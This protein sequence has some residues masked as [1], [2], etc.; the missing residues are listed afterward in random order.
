M[1]VSAILAI[2]ENFSNKKLFIIFCL[3]A[4]V[5]IDGDIRINGVP[6]GSYVHKIS[7]FMHQEDLFVGTLTV[8]EHLH[9]MVNF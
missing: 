2:I 6:V 5:F 4:G 9:F 3:A 7:G 1:Q 8:R